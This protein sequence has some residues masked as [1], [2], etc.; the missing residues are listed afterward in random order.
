M[1]PHPSPLADS[2][3]TLRAAT[4]AT[5]AHAWL[6]APIHALILACLVRIFGRLE[7]M[8]RLWQA[9]LLPPPLERPRTVRTNPANPWPREARQDSY[10]VHSLAP[11]PHGAPT[12]ART[13]DRAVAEAR[14]PMETETQREASKTLSACFS[15]SLRLH[16]E[17]LPSQPAPRRSRGSRDSL[18]PSTSPI[19]R[20]PRSRRSEVLFLEKASSAMRLSTPKSIRYRNK[21]IE[22]QGLGP[23]GANRRVFSRRGLM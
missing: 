13:A 22:V 2:V 7:E 5:P 4:L 11:A 14:I 8:I 3:A 23:I 17:I 18:P 6:P 12:H 9:G 16:V 15:S 10:S 1:P 20:R 21:L 19:T